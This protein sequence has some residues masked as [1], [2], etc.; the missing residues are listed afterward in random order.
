MNAQFVPGTVALFGLLQASVLTLLLLLGNPWS[1]GFG[2][3]RLLLINGLAA[4]GMAATTFISAAQRRAEKGTT[5]NGRCARSSG[6]L[7]RRQST[8][9]WESVVVTGFAKCMS[10]RWK[11]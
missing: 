4:T 8:D 10:L 3:G 11:Y 7:A 5:S 1:D 9:G 6:R 2:L